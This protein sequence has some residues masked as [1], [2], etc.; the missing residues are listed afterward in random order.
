[1]EDNKLDFQVIRYEEQYKSQTLELLGLL[2]SNRD[3]EAC[4]EYFKWRYEDCPYVDN[5]LLFLSVIDGKVIGVLGHMVQVFLINGIRQN[6]CVPVDGVVLSD[7][8]RFGIYNRMLVEGIRLISQLKPEFDFKLYF[9]ISSNKS[10]VGGLI[11][12]GWRELGPKKYLFSFN[13]G[14]LILGKLRSKSNDPTP[15]MDKKLNSKYSVKLSTDL[16]VDDLLAFGNTRKEPIQVLRDRSFYEWRFIHFSSR[17]RYIY[18][19]D[20]KRVVG[21]LILRQATGYEF[22]IEEYGYED[23]AQLKLMIKHAKRMLHIGIL[24]LFH[25]GLSQREL[26]ELYSAGFV[27]EDQFPLKYINKTRTSAYLRFVEGSDAVDGYQIN[28]IDS[29]SPENWR[30]FHA[31]VL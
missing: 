11:K 20:D 21:Y 8:R 17:Y 22:T 10:S 19:Y 31:D 3:A 27:P 18:L 25:I 24:R 7:Y 1:M 13:V 2:W 12:Q 4:K 6:V 26:H 14:N 15:R 9:N 30:V 5:P 28:G 29:T 23:K 16:Q